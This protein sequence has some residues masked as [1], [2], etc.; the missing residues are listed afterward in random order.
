[1]TLELRSLRAALAA[2]RILGQRGAPGRPGRDG[3]DGRDGASI[4]HGQGA[5]PATLGREED[6][7]VD[8]E[9]GD[10]WAKR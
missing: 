10:L 6:L 1:M 2:R 4:H 5:P 3:K 7:Y 9:T 8:G